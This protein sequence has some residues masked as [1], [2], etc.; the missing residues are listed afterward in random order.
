MAK[1]EPVEA[2][3]YVLK[4]YNTETKA[5]AGKDSEALY[6]TSSTNPTIDN[7]NKINNVYTINRKYYYRIESNEPVSGIEIDWDDGEDNS[8]EKGNRELKTFPEPRTI[9]IF[10][11]YYTKHKS[12]FP[13]IRILSLQNIYSKWY[14]PYHA[15]ND[16]RELDENVLAAG[17]NN[18]S[19]VSVDSSTNP[20]IPIFKPANLP[21]LAVLKAD[22]NKIYAGI[23]NAMISNMTKP[24]VFAYYPTTTFEPSDVV[25]TYENSSGQVQTQ[26]IT[27]WTDNNSVGSGNITAMSTSAG[28]AKDV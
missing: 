7:S 11:H 24:W 19:Q 14:T 4:V 27:P 3:G 6:V 5:D 21:P 18:K 16:Y 10:E 25:I 13:L 15:D 1:K 20:R 9:A 22:K 12:F 26:T 8:D 2:T 23:D 17:N 28:G